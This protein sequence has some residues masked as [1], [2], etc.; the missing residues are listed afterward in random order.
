MQGVLAIAPL[1][2]SLDRVRLWNDLLSDPRYLCAM[3][4]ETEIFSVW[5]YS[6]WSVTRWDNHSDCRQKL[7]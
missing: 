1:S 6:H 4:Q 2:G 3:V 7:G 5:H